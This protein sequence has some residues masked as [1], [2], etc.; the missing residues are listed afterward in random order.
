MDKKIYLEKS[1]GRNPDGTFKRGHRLSRGRRKTYFTKLRE[2]VH[3][4]ITIKKI[5][6]ETLE[7]PIVTLK[8]L[9]HMED[10]INKKSKKMQPMFLKIYDI[11][12]ELENLKGKI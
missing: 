8:N 6:E 4:E 11:V 5:I 3:K 10:F 1:S 9:M 7:N 12:E 2:Q